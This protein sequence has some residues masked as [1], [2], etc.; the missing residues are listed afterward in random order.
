MT[1]ETSPGERMR[2]GLKAFGWLPTEE[3]EELPFRRLR[4]S[5]HPVNDESG[6]YAGATLVGF[7]EDSPDQKVAIFAPALDSEEFDSPADSD[8]GNP[9][10][11]IP[12]KEEIEAIAEGLSVPA[13]IWTR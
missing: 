11:R 2:Q 8:T 10:G 12:S 6:E 5:L 4:S 3:G 1:D 9:V 13:D 7:F